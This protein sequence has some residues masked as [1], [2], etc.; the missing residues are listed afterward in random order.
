MVVGADVEAVA[1]KICGEEALLPPEVAVAVAAVDEVAEL[2]TAA[3]LPKL[4]LYCSTKA[5]EAA[6]ECRLYEATCR[7]TAP[8]PNRH[9]ISAKFSA[10]LSSLMDGS[11]DV[12][13]EPTG[14][15]API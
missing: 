2:A 14:L 10:I 3:S 9:R 1:L 7:D 4:S 8:N 15:K 6:S 12:A 11:A 13:T 5:P